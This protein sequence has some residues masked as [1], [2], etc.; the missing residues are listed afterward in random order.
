MDISERASFGEEI[1]IDNHKFLT[2]SVDFYSIPCEHRNR[3]EEAA[4]NFLHSVTEIC[5]D[6]KN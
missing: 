5:K 6:V 2:V 3:V 4:K 1:R